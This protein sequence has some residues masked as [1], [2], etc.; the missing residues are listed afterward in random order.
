MLQDLFPEAYNELMNDLNTRVMGYGVLLKNEIMPYVNAWSAAL[1]FLCIATI[2]ILVIVVKLNKQ[3]KELKDIVYRI[4][5]KLD[6]EKEV[7][8]NERINE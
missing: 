7:K 8:E 3:V 1:I 2:I 5:K 4:G 6:K